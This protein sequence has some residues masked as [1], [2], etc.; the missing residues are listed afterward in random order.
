MIQGAKRKLTVG[1][2]LGLGMVAAAGTPVALQTLASHG[3]DVPTLSAP[4]SLMALLDSRSPGERD[5]GV[6]TSTKSRKLASNAA[7]KPHERALGKIIRPSAAPPKEFV[8]ALAPPPPVEAAPSVAPPPTL[9]EVLPKVTGVPGNA[10]P[11]GVTLVGPPPGGTPGTPGTPVTPG[12]PGTPEVPSAVPEPA[13][14]MTML[15]GFG[16]IGS[17]MRRRRASLSGTPRLA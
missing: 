16:L 15:L 9:A 2:I 17:S 6:L 3:F 11:P 4:K 7:A 12:T 13:T 8:E 10:P 5:K 1:A 14:W